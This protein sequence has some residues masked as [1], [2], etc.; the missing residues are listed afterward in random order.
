SWFAGRRLE[1]VQSGFRFYARRVI[2][3]AGFP[4]PRFEAE[5]AIV[6]RAVRL[7]LEVRCGRIALG[8]PDGPPTSHYRPLL[9]SPPIP[10]PAR[11]RLGRL[12]IAGGVV[13]G[14][15]QPRQ[16]P[17]VARGEPRDA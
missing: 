10:P 15:L 3:R 8:E 13:R 7:G 17:L 6:V 12:R 5:S 2:D 4:E 16:G 11:P 9:A 1:D 14:R